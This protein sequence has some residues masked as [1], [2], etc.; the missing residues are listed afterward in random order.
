MCSLY[1]TCRFVE[2]AKIPHNEMLF[3]D[4]EQRN[5]IDMEKEGVKCVLV[6]DGVNM[7]LVK[8]SIDKFKN[9]SL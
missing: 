6:R 4:D 1:F 8:D 7:Q 5:I 2:Q 3:F 9:G